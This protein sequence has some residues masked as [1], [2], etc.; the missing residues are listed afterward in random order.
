MA[1]IVVAPAAKKRRSL[2]PLSIVARGKETI[3][4]F[5]HQFSRELINAMM[6]NDKYF[7]GK[8]EDGSY[9]LTTALHKHDFGD[10][11]QI[12]VQIKLSEGE[13]YENLT[14]AIM[15]LGDGIVDTWLALLAIGIETN[16]YDPTRI[17]VPFLINPDDILALQ[18]KQKTN[19]SYTPFQ[20]AEIIRNLKLLSQITVVATMEVEGGKVQGKS[21]KKDPIVLKAQGPIF[22]LLKLKIGASKLITGEEMWERR[23]VCLGAFVSDLAE[24]SRETAIMFRKVLA[25]SQKNESYQKKLGRYLSMMFRINAKNKGMWPNDISMQALLEGARIVPDRRRGEFKDALEKALQQLKADEVI[26]DYWQIVESVSPENAE[27]IEQHARGWFDL[28]LQS[29]WNFS[30]PPVIQDQ[31]ASIALRAQKAH[32]K[33]LK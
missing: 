16:G 18:C 6:D 25:Y 8:K 24:I 27:K 10:N 22:D 11:G 1:D 28:W 2:Q 15:G 29:K 32:L 9:D 12:I 30:S 21:K 17:R 14:E 23:E 33:R 31:Y 20:R 19:G 4:L 5:S 13:G 3:T 26:G 7:K